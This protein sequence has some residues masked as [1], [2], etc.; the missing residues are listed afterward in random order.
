MKHPGWN[1]FRSSLPDNKSH[2]LSSY[3]LLSRLFV[4]TIK[5]SLQLRKFDNLTLTLHSP[6]RFSSAAQAVALRVAEG[7]QREN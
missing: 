1:T 3:V 2:L 6:E 4:F 7:M 5:F